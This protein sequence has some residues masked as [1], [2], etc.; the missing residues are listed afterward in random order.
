VQLKLGL[1]IQTLKLMLAMHGAANA[2]FENAA[3]ESAAA[4][5]TPNAANFVRMTHSSD[6]KSCSTNVLPSISR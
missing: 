3:I 6:I 5:V 4:T 1:L 2:P